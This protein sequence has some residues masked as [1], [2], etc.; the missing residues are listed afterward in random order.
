MIHKLEKRGKHNLEEIKRKMTRG[1]KEKTVTI[2]AGATGE[3]QAVKTASPGGREVYEE[4]GREKEG[5]GE[6]AL[7]GGGGGRKN[8]VHPKALEIAFGM[9][10]LTGD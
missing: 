6:N 3:R 4:G 1:R 5:R 8:G 9:V 7:L 2:I 10:T